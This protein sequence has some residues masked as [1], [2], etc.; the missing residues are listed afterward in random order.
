MSFENTW[1]LLQRQNLV[2]QYATV[3]FVN[4]P[5]DL[6]INAPHS[7]WHVYAHR[8][9]YLAAGTEKNNHFINAYFRYTHPC[10]AAIVFLPKEKSLAEFLFLQL[11]SQ[12]PKG[13]P[14]FAVG[15]NDGGIRALVKKTLAGLDTFSKFASGNHCQ[16]LATQ[17]LEPQLFEAASTQRRLTINIQQQ[18]Y[19][20]VFLPGVFGENKLDSGTEFLLQ[21]IPT[22]LA[23]S[24]LDFGCGSGVISAWLCANRPISQLIAADIST[25]AVTA[26]EQTLMLY[27][28]P[29]EVRLSDGFHNITERFDWIVTNPPFHQGKRND[30]RIT[31]EFIQSLKQ[32]LKPNGQVI[33][34]ANHFLPWPSLLQEEFKTVTTVAQNSRYIISL[35]R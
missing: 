9:A 34:V 28:L 8:S 2:E 11:A 4:P 15:P 16:L 14:I 3:L 30:Y 20:I 33:M 35:A 18:P 22:K 5:A 32:H 31:T 25:L 13:T 12:L 10:E 7:A 1:R 26:A 21:H 27:D 23:G 24:V 17:L 29:H 6:A 19:D